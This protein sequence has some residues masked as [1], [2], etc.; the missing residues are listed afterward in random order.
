MEDQ[1]QLTH[2]LKA[3]VKGLHKNL[4]HMTTMIG[5][6]KMMILTMPH[7]DEVENTQLRFTAVHTE[8][9]VKSGVVT[10]D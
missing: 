10:V 7:L 8:D 2:I 9:E 1:I 4:K 6:P 5:L 3:L